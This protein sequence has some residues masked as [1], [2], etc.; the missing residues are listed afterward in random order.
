V[1]V[2]SRDRVEPIIKLMAPWGFPYTLVKVGPR[3]G[4][5]VVGSGAVYKAAAKQQS[6]PRD[7]HHNQT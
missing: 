1:T 2:E 7:A 6:R 3:E 4:Y 5:N